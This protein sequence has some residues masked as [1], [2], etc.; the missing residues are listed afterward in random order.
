MAE[1]RPP[2]FNVPL[3]FY[4]GPEVKS[5]PRRIRAAA[6]GV[7][8]LCGCFSANK[9]QDGYVGPEDLKNLGCTDAIRKAL[10]A[11][12][13]PD[14]EPDPLWI[15]A[16][17]GGIQFTK[18]V[19]YQR[20]RAEVKAYREADAERKRQERKA[21]GKAS[22]YGPTSDDSEMSERTGSGHYS[23]VH[24]DSGTP[25]TKT[26]TKTEENSTFVC[27]SPNVGGDER[28]LTE[29]VN[30]SASRL[31]ATLIPDTI[32]AAVRT[33]LRLKASELI[34]RD[35]LDTD[36]VA[37]A[38]RRW[39]SRPGAGVGLLPSFAADVIRERTAPAKPSSKVRGYAELAAEVRAA[40]QT[41]LVAT[42]PKEI[43]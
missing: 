12:K 29:P 10:K 36:T 23:D 20:S 34:N 28:G 25:K 43:S 35:D 15:D 32:P 4:D 41:Q 17:D 22:E 13:G 40:E 19:K 16:R 31:V 1:R 6:V 3:G 30:V 21:K 39:L 26:E 9:L 18:W 33:G 8:T 5:I 27:S 2:G 37:E 11:T 14:G 7:W 24:P 38:L 42:R